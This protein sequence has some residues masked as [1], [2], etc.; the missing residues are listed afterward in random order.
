MEKQ[1]RIL[2]TSD[3]HLCRPL[4][5]RR[6]D[7]EYAAMLSFILETLKNVDYDLL[8]VAGDV[9]DTTQPSNRALA[10]YHRFLA[11]AHNLVPHIVVIAGNHDSP[12]LLASSKP[13]LDYLNIHIVASAKDDDE[14]IELKDEE[15][16]I[17][18]VVAAVP[19]LRD[20]DIRK[21]EADEK[22]EEAEENSAKAVE[23]HFAE[24]DKMLASYQGLGIPLIG[25]AHL[26]AAG[27]EVKRDEGDE[28]LKVGSLSQIEG[29]KLFPHAAYTALGHIHMM[30]RVASSDC[31]RYSGS[32]L[33]QN[34]GERSDKKCLLDVEFEN[35]ELRKVSAVEV[36]EMVPLISV[37]GSFA[38]IQN[39]L[40][41][42]ENKTCYLS[43]IYTEELI[44]DS[45]NDEVAVLVKDKDNV[46]LLSVQ[47]PNVLRT[48]SITEVGVELSSLKPEDVF[49]KL[50]DDKNYEEEKKEALKE[51]F[52]EILNADD[53]GDEE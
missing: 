15:G 12:S 3:W 41:A 40:K 48:F 37:K 17:E 7:D 14:I 28:R 46:M 1:F 53:E 50:L 13:V 47:A 42:L 49:E 27:S 33:A 35:G 24:V 5:N 11:E 23:A 32:P 18:A 25:T 52:L 6:R 9:F 39:L 20:S 45:L 16:N 30:Q 38:E 26:F 43:V 19:Y 2:H 4:F 31:I 51:T 44:R 34:F 8:I 36:P 22:V 10:L 29:N 21:I